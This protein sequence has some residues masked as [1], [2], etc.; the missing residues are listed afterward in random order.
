[1]KTLMG[2]TALTEY[3]TVNLPGEPLDAIPLLVHA[4]EV[5]SPYIKNIR[6]STSGKK[7]TRRV[8]PHCCLPP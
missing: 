7:G 4:S 3:T 2:N 6:E 1:M 8:N 5:V